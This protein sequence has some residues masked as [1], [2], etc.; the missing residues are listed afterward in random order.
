MS[1]SP[2]VF[3]APAAV[4]SIIRDLMFVLQ[5]HASGTSYKFNATD[6]YTFKPDDGDVIMAPRKLRRSP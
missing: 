5:V 2:K 4:L 3:R 6:V 1:D